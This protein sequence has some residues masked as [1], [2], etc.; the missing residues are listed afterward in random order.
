M[1]SIESANIVRSGSTE[2]VHWFHWLGE[3][4]PPPLQI[5]ESFDFLLPIFR[6]HRCQPLSVVVLITHFQS[7]FSIIDY[8]L[9][10]SII[11]WHDWHPTKWVPPV[12]KLRITSTWRFAMLNK[13][14][15]N[16][17]SSTQWK[18]KL[19]TRKMERQYDNNNNRTRSIRWLMN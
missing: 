16:A 6:H 8:K 14:I 2:S 5:D 7:S 3:T 19:K 13:H 1:T 11:I 15:K 10:Y 18:M 9:N 12:Q 17:F 4:P